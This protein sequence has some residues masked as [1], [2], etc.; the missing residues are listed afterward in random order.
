MTP[1]H[2]RHSDYG[3]LD[4]LVQWWGLFA[5]LLAIVVLTTQCAKLHARSVKTTANASSI[6]IREAAFY[7]AVTVECGRVAQ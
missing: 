1:W 4:R 7:D 2:S 3:Y 6:C 5:F